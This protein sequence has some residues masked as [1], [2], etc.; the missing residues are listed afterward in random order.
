MA[1]SR[2]CSYF[3]MSHA[4]RFVVVDRE[5]HVR[6]LVGNRRTVLSPNNS[7]PRQVPSVS[8][9]NEKVTHPGTKRTVILT[10]RFFSEHADKQS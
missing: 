4:I 1:S 8:M 5:V 2:Q 9:N 7:S 3:E 6:I 10:R